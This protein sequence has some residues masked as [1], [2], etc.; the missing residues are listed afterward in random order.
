MTG[1]QE[2]RDSLMGSLVLDIS[3]AASTDWK[4]PVTLDDGLRLALAQRSG[5]SAGAK[6]GSSTMATAITP[7]NRTRER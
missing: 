2:A 3:K 4:P 7:A 5:R 1:R 6:N